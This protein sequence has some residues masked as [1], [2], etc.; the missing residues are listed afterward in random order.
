M[1]VYVEFSGPVDDY[2]EATSFSIGMNSSGFAGGTARTAQRSEVQFTKDRDSL[3]HALM[4]HS[5]AGTVFGT[6]WVEL[7]QD[8]DSDVYITYTMRDVVISSMSSRDNRESVGL[9]YRTSKANYF[10]R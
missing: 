3:S 5:A 6:V 2:C 4:Q 9:N 1:L 8:A 7:Y 10:G